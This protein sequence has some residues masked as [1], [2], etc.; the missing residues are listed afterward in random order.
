MR[1]LSLPFN[2]DEG[3]PHPM[4]QLGIE[5]DRI[6]HNPFIEAKIL[7]NSD[8]TAPEDLEQVNISEAKATNPKYHCGLYRPD[9]VNPHEVRSV[10]T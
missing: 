2:D 6:W 9:I 8:R 1:E 7:S 4:A 3:P 10:E 5:L